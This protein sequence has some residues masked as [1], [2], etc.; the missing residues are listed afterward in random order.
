MVNKKKYF[1]KPLTRGH[2]CCIFASE[3][4]RFKSVDDGY[5]ENKFYTLFYSYENQE[6]VQEKFVQ[7]RV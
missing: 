6:K 7:K 2:L 5:F 4:S 1:A 3:N